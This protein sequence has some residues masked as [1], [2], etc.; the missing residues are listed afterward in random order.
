MV[1]NNGYL[2]VTL[3]MP[4]ILFLGAGCTDSGTGELPAPVEEVRPGILKG[5]LERDE[6]LDSLG[7]LPVPPADN[8][9]AFRRDAA[10]SAASL[11][12]RDTPAWKQAALDA[13]LHMPAAIENFVAA[14]DV[15]VSEAETPFTYQLLRR[16]MADAGL[17][18]YGAKNEYQRA[19][20]FTVNGQPTCTPDDEEMLRNDGSYPSGHTALGWAWALILAELLPE[21]ADAII[22]RGYNYGQSRV[23]CNVHWQS[24]VDAGRIIGSATVARLHADEDFLYD[25]AMARKEMARQ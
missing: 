24:D 11:E 16:A 9:G 10:F 8:S 22:K 4:L 13:D 14:L 12:L 6:Q 2:N 23:I 19:R 15:E 1:V 17:S 3:V 18:T 21:D 7:L 20:P 5:Y 25:L